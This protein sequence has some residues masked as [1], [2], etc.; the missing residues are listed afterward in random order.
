MILME[1][2]D[3]DG[4]AASVRLPGTDFRP[5]LTATTRAAGTFLARDLMFAARGCEGRRF[6]KRRS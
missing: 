1:W 5:Q 2:K 6:D 3:S 4:K